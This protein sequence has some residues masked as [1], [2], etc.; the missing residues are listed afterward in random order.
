MQI[1]SLKNN[2]WE[3]SF[4]HERW[5]IITSIKLQ[6]EEILFL[7]SDTFYD[8]SKNVRWWIPVMFPNSWPLRENEKYNL[9][10]HWFARNLPWDYETNQ[11]EVIMTLQ[12]NYETK[13]LYNYDFILQ[14][15]TRIINETKIEII[16]KIINNW[17]QILPVSPWLHPYFFVKNEEKKDI[18][19]YLW[20]ELLTDYSFCNW[21]T[22]YLNN[23]W[24]IKLVFKNWQI[25]KLNYSKEYK[26]LW[27]R[28]EQWKDFVCIEPVAW[29][30]HDLLYNP[31][32]IWIWK[33]MEYRVEITKLA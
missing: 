33:S 7:N 19:I 3:I 18:K 10:Q 12:S 9:K 17:N 5:W 32:M 2:W 8:T 20:N 16:Q 13:K 31:D 30:E 26:K 23:P 1:N 24:I 22:V 25:L 6:T 4:S 27:I 29:N 28:S 11:N 14:I 15:I 21:Q